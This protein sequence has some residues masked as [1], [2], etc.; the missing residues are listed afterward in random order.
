[1]YEW[2]TDALRESSQVVT[3]NRRLARVL[4]DHYGQQQ[5]E[6][7][8]SAWRSPAIRS[9]QDWLGDVYT[10]AELS[11][12]H[13]VRINPHQ[14]RVLWEKCLRR[15][16]A[17][18][19]LNMPMLVR[20]ARETWARLHEFE[21]PLGV[22]AESAAGRDQN[23]FARAAKG[24]Q[25]ILDAEGWV[26]EAGLAKQ[27]T[28]MISGGVAPLPARVTLAGFDRLSPQVESVLD[29][30]RAS[31]VSVIEAT[32][33]SGADVAKIHSYDNADA[34]MR[35]AGAWA[36]KQLQE[37]P[38]GI[39]GIV[40]MHLDKDA[41]RCAR[42]VREGLVPGWQCAGDEYEGAVNV[43]FGGSLSE[44][45]AI[46]VALLALRWLHSDLAGRDVSTLLR[47]P[48]FGAS[49]TGG[50]SRLELSLRR[51]P[52]RSWSPAMVLG[53]FRNR[54]ADADARDW[55]QRVS[56]IDTRRQQ[57]PRR[58]APSEWV[59][60]IDD[61]LKALNWPGGQPLDSHE[62]QLVN[63][64]RE[65][66]NDFARLGLVSA[67]MTPGEAL[68][69]L[70]AMAGETV[71]QPESKGAIAQLLGPLEAAGMEFD[72]LWVS[73]L[74]AANWP[75]P[76]RPSALLSRRLQRNYG[77][78]DADPDDTLAYAERV[79][80]RLF[81]AAKQVQGSFSVT[82]GDA[83]QTASGLLDNR[84]QSSETNARDPGWYA[85]QLVRVTSPKSFSSDPVPPVSN[86][87]SITGG[88]STINHQ[89]H[90]PFSAFCYGRL[91]IRPLTGIASGLAA[92]LRGSL[93]H[94]ALR[95]LYAERPSQAEIVSWDEEHRRQRIDTALRAAFGDHDRYADAVLRA[96]LQLEQRRDATLLHA[97]VEQDA[98]R[99]AFNIL[100]VEAALETAI[101][102][103]RLS[104][105]IDRVDQ[106]DD[107]GL[108]I[109]DYKTGSRK[110]FR[111]RDGLPNDMQLV[112]YAL[113]VSD[114][115]AGLGLI[116]IDSRAVDLNGAGRA[117]TPDLDWDEALAGWQ[118]EVSDAAHDIQRGDVR[119]N[120]LLDRR[121]A[122]P[123]SLLSRIA[124]LRRDD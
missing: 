88:A 124:E 103:V 89:L 23:I 49:S 123:L 30:L 121:A 12:A 8:R 80:T 13:P 59:V 82:D 67:S 118:R 57:L 16:I 34:E 1:M 37:S 75:P 55:L 96:L 112:V 39:V 120:G 27:V 87:E 100:E 40:A 14:S 84:S 116:N 91:G 61:T 52:D 94:D 54:A 81:A 114:A 45:P 38:D 99:P 105:R 29:T 33:Q 26:D 119:I 48:A 15:E 93:I 63:R 9:W 62:F 47:S 68:R 76:G 53:L 104:L 46:A 51:H 22:C 111:N 117:F 32:G 83:E 24:Y 74:S 28:A 95:N 56:S 58:A 113:A 5:L 35:A 73:G 97:V 109:L 50:R 41:P 79:L 7:G 86:V 43:S 17:D 78:P 115:V 11:S 21:V 65:L 20:Q 90:E 69:R 44:Y 64:W 3:A 122:R 42:L 25:S 60:L 102:G 66:L 36:R 77:M 18:P 31:A 71:F 106:L 85:A 72:R 108:V 70:A 2:L 98:A 19:L 101:Q 107:G 4:T 6:L 10:V 110:A 92:S